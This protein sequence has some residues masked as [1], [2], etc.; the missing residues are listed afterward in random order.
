MRFLCFLLWLPLLSFADTKLPDWTF[1]I[2]TTG[3]IGPEQKFESLG[4]AIIPSADVLLEPYGGYTFL[5]R[6]YQEDLN[7]V[8]YTGIWGHAQ[9]FQQFLKDSRGIEIPREIIAMKLGMENIFTS[10]SDEAVTNV[11][12]DLGKNLSFEQKIAFSSQLGGIL[13]QGY[14][15]SRVEETSGVVSMRDMIEARRNG[16]AAGICRD[17]SFAVAQSL[18][19]MG[20]KETFIVSFQTV[21]GGHT[22]IIVQD[23]ENSKKTYTINYDAV[24]SSEGVSPLSHLKQDS[25]NPG[26]GIDYRIY[27]ADGVHLT[28]LPTHLGVILEEMIGGNLGNLDPMV[29]SENQLLTAALENKNGFQAGASTGYTP[30]G[31]LVVAAHSSYTIDS[32]ILPGQYAIVLYN[33]RGDTHDW[34]AKEQTGFYFSGHQKIYSPPLTVKVRG[35]EVRMRVL[36][37]ADVTSFYGKGDIQNLSQDFWGV[38]NNF[39]YGAGSEITFESAGGKT[40]IQ[41]SL[42]ATGGFGKSDVRDE[43]SYRTDFRDITAMI[44]LNQRISQGIEGFVRATFVQRRQ[45]LGAQSRQEAGINFDLKNYRGSVVVGHEGQVIGQP[46]AFLPGSTEKYFMET[47]YRTSRGTKISGGVFCGT[48]STK[49]CGL[50]VSGTFVLP[51]GWENRIFRRR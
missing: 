18:K 20:A 45:E 25:G 29:R 14:D 6:K 8:A 13:F 10:T 7:S 22:T 16:Q 40:K 23:P 21:G 47:S 36:G 15:Y 4:K 35:G 17:M 49:D 33:A 46:L 28:S 9:G 3:T 1:S 42:T 32:K 51:L 30:D 27:S 19:E 50:R 34:G 24:T 5:W 26:L 44:T 48:S 43:E 12:R 2:E 11:Y 37:K 39:T 38:R 41:G 31:D